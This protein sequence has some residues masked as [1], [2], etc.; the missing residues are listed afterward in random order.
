MQPIP[1]SSSAQMQPEAIPVLVRDIDAIRQTVD[2]PISFSP[3]GRAVS[4]YPCGHTLEE[5]SAIRLGTRNISVNPPDRAIDDPRLPVCPL[6][7][8]PILGYIP[9]LVVREVVGQFERVFD[10]RPDDEPHD[11][12]GELQQNP[13]YIRAAAERVIATERLASAA[14]ATAQARAEAERATAAERAV[15]AEIV[16]VRAEAVAVRAQVAAVRAEAARIDAAERAVRAQVLEMT[17]KS[18]IERSVVVITL[19]LGT[20]GSSF[21]A[22][23]LT[24]IGVVNSVIKGEQGGWF[25]K[26][27]PDQT[28]STFNND[29]KEQNTQIV[30]MATIATAIATIFSLLLVSCCRRR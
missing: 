4:L 24:P 10:R 15:R 9:S 28:I 14:R 3:M 6:D 30:F 17:K 2:C 26:G 23:H 29:V 12:L 22:F 18:L 1:S 25:R 13:E 7:R 20:I 8:T 5:E 16:G 27:T 21:A 11:K 19:L